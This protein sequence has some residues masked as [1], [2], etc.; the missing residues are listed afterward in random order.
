MGM[1]DGRGRACL[2]AGASLSLG[3]GLRG[4]PPVA[5]LAV[6]RVGGNAIDS[7]EGASAGCGRGDSRRVGATWTCHPVGVVRRPRLVPPKDD[8]HSPMMVN[9]FGRSVCSFP[10]SQAGFHEP[11]RLPHPPGP[12]DYG[13]GPETGVVKGRGL[14]R[15]GL[16]GPAWERRPFIDGV[17]PR[18]ASGKA[19]SH[20]T[21]T[22]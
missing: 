15:L 8:H 18:L 7:D 2:R 6:A 19:Y 11:P 17:R 9:P 5:G 13:P 21:M 10:R 22:A 3:V 16:A 4:G 14:G 1:G 20:S 12:Y